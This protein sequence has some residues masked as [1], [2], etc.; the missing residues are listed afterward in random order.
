MIVLGGCAAVE[1]AS[2]KAG[3]DIDVP[4]TPGRTDATQEKTDIEAFEPLE[5]NADGFRNYYRNRD[6]ISASSEELLLDR[7][8]LLTLTA[9]EMTALVGG[10]RVLDANYDG[11]KK[12]VFT[13]RPG[14]LTNDYF[15][16]VLDL[17]TTWKGK[18]DSEIEFEGSDRNSG[19]V[20][21]EGSRVDLIFGS[22]SELRA[23][24]EVYGTDD[25]Q[26]KFV[27]DFVAAWD[28]V[29]NLDRFDL[30]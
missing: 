25:G 11:S 3:Y 6:H 30:K 5:P 18:S 13:D 19:D 12:G 23:I 4:F 17:R 15:V 29:M 7:A 14:T 27:H 22:N 8:Q 24:S 21:W 2:R 10:M 9:P 16:N 1:K 28:K 26:E 20:K